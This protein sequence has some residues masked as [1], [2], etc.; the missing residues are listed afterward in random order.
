MILKKNAPDERN[1]RVDE[2][3]SRL[4]GKNNNWSYCDGTS[5]Y[6]SERK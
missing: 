2:R 1:N 6:L 3:N 5:V 4:I